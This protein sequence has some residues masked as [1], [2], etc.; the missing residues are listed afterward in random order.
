MKKQNDYFDT[1]V[2]QVTCSVQAAQLLVQILSAFQPETA[3]KRREEMHQVEHVADEIRHDALRKLAREFIAPIERDDLLHLIQIIDDVTDAID[4]VPIDLYAFNIRRL[5][6]DAQTLAGLVE[7]C[8]LSLQ[9]AVT[10][11]KHFKKSDK[12]EGLLIAVNTLESEGDAAYIE[13]MR[14]LFTTEKDPIA[15][16]GVKA[17]YDSLESCCDLCEHAADVIENTVMNNT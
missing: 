7:K 17:I 10:E 5:P 2:Q 9:K 11:L 16:M 4:E 14:R 13:A 15:L 8:V 3:Q 6:P 12:L 1:M